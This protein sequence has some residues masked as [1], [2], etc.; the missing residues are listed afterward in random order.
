MLGQQPPLNGLSA[1]SLAPSQPLP[2]LLLD[3]FPLGW[4]FK[5]QV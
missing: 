5:G 2:V 3:D 1:L 4:S